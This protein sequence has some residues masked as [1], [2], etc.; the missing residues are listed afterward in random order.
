[1]HYFDRGF[2]S[3]SFEDDFFAVMVRN[4]RLERI[5]IHGLERREPFMKFVELRNLSPSEINVFKFADRI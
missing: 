3:Y 4:T 1:M 5:T 2:P